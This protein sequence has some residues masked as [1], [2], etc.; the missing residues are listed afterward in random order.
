[1]KEN[2]VEEPSASDTSKV[3]GR[4]YVSRTDCP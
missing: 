3:G 2:S 4:L 1:M